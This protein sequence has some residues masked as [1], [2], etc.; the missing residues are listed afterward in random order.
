[1]TSQSPRIY[2]YKIT[3]EEVPY[4]YY[5][6]KKEKVFD[7]EYWGSPVTNKWCWELYTPK[8]QILEVFDYTDDGYIKA[9]KVEGRLIRPS[10]N[11]DKWCLNANCLGVFSIE[12]KR[13]AGKIGGE[14]TGKENGRKTGKQM[15]EEQ[16]GCFSLS[17]EKRTELSREIALRH[18]ENKTAIFSLTPEERKQN[19]IKGGL[20]TKERGNGIFNISPEEHLKNCKKGAQKTKELGL[21]I[22]ELTPEQRIENSRKSGIKT[23]DLKIGVHGLTPEQKSEAG[24]KGGLKCKENKSGVCGISKEQR[25]QNVK[26]TNSQKWMCAETGFITNSGSLSRYQKARGID[27][28]KRVRLK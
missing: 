25:Q 19:S 7:E 16:K 15:F 6:S 8:K 18:K 13:K 22:Y 12:Q 26:K 20:K 14:I 1:M 23:R 5:G 28:S 3:F 27:T 9:Q 24:K 4:Y 17:P 10:Y 11:T 2:T 21:G